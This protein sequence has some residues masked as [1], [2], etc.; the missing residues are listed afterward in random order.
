MYRYR[1]K[2]NYL[3][4]D[5]VIDF[6]EIDRYRTKENYLKS[7]VVIQFLMLKVLGIKSRAVCMPSRGSRQHYFTETCS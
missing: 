1:T 2:E 4:S 5:T 6:L 3:K 7:D